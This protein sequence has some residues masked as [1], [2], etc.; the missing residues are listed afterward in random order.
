MEDNPHSQAGVFNP[1]LRGV[2]KPTMNIDY[3]WWFQIFFPI[4]TPNHGE[5]IQFEK[6]YFSDGLN[7]QL[8]INH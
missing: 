2:I 8:D 7:H 3:R 6:E 5:M 1:L 4:F